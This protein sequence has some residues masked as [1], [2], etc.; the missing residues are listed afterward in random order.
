MATETV[1]S[2]PGI[3]PPTPLT[4][5]SG[6]ENFKEEMEMYFIVINQKDTKIQLTT[7][8]YQG[9]AEL[10]R[11]WKTIKPTTDVTE[12]HYNNAVKLLDDYF[13]PKKNLTFERSKFRAAVQKT[14]QGFME[15]LTELKELRTGCEFD[16]Y[17][18][19]TAVIDQFIEKCSSARL[20]KQ[21]LGTIDLTL[22]KLTT[23]ARGEELSDKRA[24]VIENRLAHSTHEP[25]IKREP[26]DVY[27]SS[28]SSYRGRGSR[29]GQPRQQPMICY[30]CGSEKH[31]FGDDR[32]KAKDM[33]CYNRPSLRKLEIVV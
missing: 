16:K 13:L 32:C 26:E 3:T 19:E 2:N 1:I 14:G 9:G 30:G 15:Y 7:L 29:G 8:L 28:G 33:E 20:R 17:T 10:R 5:A 24:E 31:V 18:P 4:N 12:D 11:I 23:M 22:D 27:Y 6:W 21:L 25:V